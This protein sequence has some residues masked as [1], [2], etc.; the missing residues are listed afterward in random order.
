MIKRDHGTKKNTESCLFSDEIY[1]TRKRMNKTIYSK[2]GS[3][4]STRTEN[5]SKF[6]KV[7]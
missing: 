1:N 5:S 6:T 7:N 2:F 3:K 4:Y